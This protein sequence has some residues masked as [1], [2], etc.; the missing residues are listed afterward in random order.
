MGRGLGTRDIAQQLGLSMKTIETYQARIKEKLGLANG[1]EL[2]RAAVS[3][4]QS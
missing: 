3:W 4:T 2:M 1:H